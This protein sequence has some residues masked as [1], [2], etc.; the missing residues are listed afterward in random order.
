MNNLINKFRSWMASSIAPAQPTGNITWDPRGSVMAS[1]MANPHRMLEQPADRTVSL[2]T[3]RNG[4]ILQVG[5]YKPNPRGADWTY[6][7][8]LVADGE[9]VADAVASQLVAANMESR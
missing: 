3:A 9:S 7:Y 1:D 5:V 6:Y 2:Y 8:Y 4:K